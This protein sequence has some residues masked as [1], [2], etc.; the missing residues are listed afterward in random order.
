MRHLARAGWRIRAVGRREPL[1]LFLKSMG[2]VGQ[3][4][5]F[6]ADIGEAQLLPPLLEHS[7]LAINLVAILR[8]TGNQR[9]G[10]LHEEGAEHIA[11]AAKEAGVKGLIH[12][13]ALGASEKSES[14]YM[15]SKRRGLLA[16]REIFPKAYCLSPS[17]VFGPEDSFFNRFAAM[18]R[19]APALPLIAEGTR[20][21]PIYVGDVAAAVAK[22]AEHIE[23]REGA[24]LAKHY[25][26]GGPQIY[27]MRDLMLYIL[28]TIER[29]RLLIPL[30]HFLAKTLAAIGNY[31]PWAPITSD[32]L[33]AL[34]KDNLV[35]A[36]AK[37]EGRTLEGLGITPSP[38][39]EIVPDYLR[40]YRKFGG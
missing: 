33:A 10:R 27:T 36:R 24:S 14:A 6:A 11:K 21:Q 18:A 38:L 32:E 5:T 3:I 25:E 9:F 12:L 16:V 4:E 22:I 30:P 8:E 20:F 13:S 26:L 40:R 31:W 7:D 37:G 34:M 39:E 28:E 23:K 35:S 15:R 17:L 19:L 29:P 2:E 1:G